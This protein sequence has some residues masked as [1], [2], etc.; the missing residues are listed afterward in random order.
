MFEPAAVSATALIGR[1]RGNP[2][3]PG[4][5]IPGVEAES[6]HAGGT[7]RRMSRFEREE[8]ELE[9]SRI[10]AFSDGV[11]AIA[12]TLLVLSLDVPQ[13]ASDIGDELRDQLPNFFAFALSF[14]VLARVWLFHHRLFGA[15]SGFDGRLITFNFVYLALVT[16]V[17]FSCE[18]VGDYGEESHAVVFYAANMGL[19]GAIGGV[20]VGYAFRRDLI[21]Q[22]AA[23]IIGI[24]T[25]P[26]N[27]VVAAVF[28][29]SIPVA[30]LSPTVA[31]VMWVSLFAA[32]G[33]MF[34]LVDR[35]ARR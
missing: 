29:L 27:W 4:R 19:L 17:P 25:G 34:N 35:W 2:S 1:S 31:I 24:G 32:A 10:V 18:L 9:F 22:R 7:G 13:S 16:M 20:I 6:R 21:D 14:A 30:L 33:P 23:A 28:L 26:S 5:M 11:F 15:M 8:R 3:H 12:I